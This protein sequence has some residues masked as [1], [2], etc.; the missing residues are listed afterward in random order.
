MWWSHARVALDQERH[1]HGNE[2]ASI[3]WDRITPRHTVCHRLA[4]HAVTYARLEGL[5][6][7]R[8][9]LW[10]RGGIPCAERR[11]LHESVLARMII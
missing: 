8:N 5:E 4:G 11:D 9:Q 2:I 6:L 3:R 1:G 7:A 10:S